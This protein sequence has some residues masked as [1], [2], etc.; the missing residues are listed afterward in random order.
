[1]VQRKDLLLAVSL[2]LPL[3]LVSAHGRPA[4][5]AQDHPVFRAPCPRTEARP[6][7]PEPTRSRAAPAPAESAAPTVS[8][9]PPALSAA[10]TMSA[11]PPAESPAP[12]ASAEPPTSAE[13]A[14]AAPPAASPATVSAEDATSSPAA[15]L[16]SAAP[17]ESPPVSAPTPGA[18]PEERPLIELASAATL[19]EPPPAPNSDAMRALDD[20]L[21]GGEPGDPLATIAPSESP[22]PSV[23]TPSPEETSRAIERVLPSVRA[24][25]GDDASGVVVLR[26]EFVSS[27]RASAVLVQSQS[28]HLT[29]RERSCIARA[30]RRAQVSA[31]QRS[32]FALSYPVR[33]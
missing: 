4:A 20:V 33:L 31:F 7:A 25:V 32:H 21:S 3:S 22:A 5:S 8:A 9:A 16:A 19:A 14:S 6:H 30:A 23:E 15:E 18:L 26:L 27:G 12:A 1:M 28:A 2:A 11:A 13:V 29:H 10:P 24:C 17:P